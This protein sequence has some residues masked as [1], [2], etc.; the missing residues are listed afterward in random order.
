MELLPPVV[1]EHKRKVAV[2]I[3]EDNM[4]LLKALANIR[5]LVPVSKAER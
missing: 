3:N 2:E 1:G 4:P 5:N